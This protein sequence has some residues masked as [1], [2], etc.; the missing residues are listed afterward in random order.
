[1]KDLKEDYDNL[2][3]TPFEEAKKD[4]SKNL[5]D[6]NVSPSSAFI[7]GGLILV[8]IVLLGFSL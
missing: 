6:L 4:L 7:I 2:I 8:V 5:E 3:D 1:M